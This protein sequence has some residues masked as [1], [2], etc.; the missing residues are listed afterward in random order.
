MPAKLGVDKV[1]QGGAQGVGDQIVDVGDTV[2]KQ[3]GQFDTQGGKKTN[4]QHLSEP[5]ATAAYQGEKQSHWQKQEDIQNTV[6]QI[7]NKAGKGDQ[8]QNDIK[9]HELHRG[10]AHQAVH[11][12]PVE[13]QTITPEGVAKVAEAAPVEQK[14]TG[15]QNRCGA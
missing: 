3:L 13:G 2:G 8:I 10:K 9:G 4:L 7:V 1:A 6:S 15:K 12:A 14:K 11:H 5:T